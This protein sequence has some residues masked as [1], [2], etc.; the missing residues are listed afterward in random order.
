ML[1]VKKFGNKGFGNKRLGNIGFENKSSPNR[2]F[3]KVN[4]KPAQRQTALQNS[5]TDLLDVICGCVTNPEMM[6]IMI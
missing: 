4:V 1:G 5:S 2:D 6:H 3:V